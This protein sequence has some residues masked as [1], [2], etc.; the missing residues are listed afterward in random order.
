MKIGGTGEQGK[1]NEARDD[2][3]PRVQ[4]NKTKAPVRRQRPGIERRNPAD[5]PAKA[6]LSKKPICCLPQLCKCAAMSERRGDVSVEIPH[7]PSGWLQPIVTSNFV[8]AID[9]LF[10][11][12]EPDQFGPPFGDKQIAPSANAS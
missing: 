12:D 10:N 1:L 5:G 4:V 7:E 11:P 2:K 9:L 3:D 8:F 6:V